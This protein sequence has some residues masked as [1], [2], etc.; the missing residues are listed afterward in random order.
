M[1]K[2]FFTAVAIFISI[3]I[4]AQELPELP[5]PPRMVND[6]AGVLTSEENQQL[7]N[8]LVQFNNESSSQVAI[9]V[10]NSLEG[11]SVDDFAFKL[12]QKWGIG[13]AGKNN[14][15]LILVKPKVGNEKG[16]AFIATGYGLEGA[17]PDAVAHRIVNAEMIPEFKNGNYYGGM[18]KAVSV[19]M[20]LTKN[21]YTADAYMK[22]SEKSKGGSLIIVIALIIF[23]VILSKGSSKNQT[24][25]TSKGVKGSS[26]PFWL[27]M[28]GMASS[29][30]NS[31]G[32]GGFSSGSGGF[33][34]F[35][36]GG[37]GGGGAG[38]SW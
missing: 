33:G 9:V 10:V 16:K 15:I 23:L 31:G 26:L 13:Q 38:G 6:F 18:A 21:E 29:S 8:T 25:Y 30:R 35:C 20:E 3:V 36:G 14:G 17:V 11:T 32:F 27:L 2:Y 24:S 1:I 37:F 5:N 34:G 7:E 22:K 19:I 28:G 12:G 4:S